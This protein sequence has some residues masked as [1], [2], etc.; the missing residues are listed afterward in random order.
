MSGC[1]LFCLIVVLLLFPIMACAQDTTAVSIDE[2]VA[3]LNAQCPI[4]YSDN[5]GLN[6]FTMVDNRYA[7]VDIQLPSNLSMIL[8]SLTADTD[9]VRKL[10]IKQFEQYGERW[11]HFVDMMVEADRRIIIN[12]RPGD[13]EDTALMTFWPTDFNQDGQ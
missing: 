2:Y 12:L 7:L 9:N 4:S 3:E 6:S 1:K 5:W 11:N 8:S 13:S 10:W